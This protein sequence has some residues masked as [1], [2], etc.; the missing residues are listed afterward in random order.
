MNCWGFGPGFAARLEAELV[1]FLKAR[2]GEPKA[3][4]YLPTAVS[5]MVAAG[6]ACVRIL[7]TTSHWFGV[8]YREDR[9]RVAEALAGLVKAGAYP[10]PLF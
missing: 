3:E 8:T 2:I 6:Q 4:F 7:P 5:S 10:D 1:A 9:P